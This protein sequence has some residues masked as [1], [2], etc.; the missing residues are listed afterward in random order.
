MM[1]KNLFESPPARLPRPL[2]FLLNRRT[3][4]YLLPHHHHLTAAA[5]KAIT[6]AA[7]VPWLCGAPISL[8]LPP[9]PFQ[10]DEL[11]CPLIRACV[12]M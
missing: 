12:A 1:T 10:R 5:T 9:F 2:C 7:I 6:A 8:S 4:P 11:S 3:P